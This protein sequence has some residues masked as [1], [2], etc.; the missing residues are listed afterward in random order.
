MAVIARAQNSAFGLRPMNPFRDLRGVADLI[1]EAFADDLDQAGQNALR[2][3]RWLSRMKPVLWWMTTFNAEYSDFLTGFVWEEDGRIVGNV[4]VSQTSPGSQRWL[5]SNV[6]VS[7]PYRGRG[8]ARCLMDAA[9][10]LVRECRGRVVTLQ[11][12]ANNEPARHLYRSLNFCEV[13]GTVYMTLPYI[14]AVKRSVFPAEVRF[15]RRRFNYVDTLKAYQ[16]ACAATPPEVQ[17]EWPVRRSRFQVGLDAQLAGLFARLLGGPASAFWVV[18]KEDRFVG[19]MNI[20]AGMFGQSHRLELFVDPQW[21]GKLEHPL[22]S[23]ALQYL[24]KWG[25]WGVQVRH[26]ADHPEAVEVYR[27]LGFQEEQTLIWMKRE[28]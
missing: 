17:K 15:R 4:T 9:L 2:E 7:R 6:A 22:I 26:P 16:L 12:R 10:E 21:R 13:T 19:M 5:I 27:A 24:Q 18:E 11:V 23:R 20:Y 14:P 3:L 8:I 25:A 28:M 1:A